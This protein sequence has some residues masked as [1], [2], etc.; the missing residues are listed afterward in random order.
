MVRACRQIAGYN[1]RWFGAALVYGT[2]HP[3]GGYGVSSSG[4]GWEEA[5][6]RLLTKSIQLN[7][8]SQTMVLDYK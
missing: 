5:V 2:I 6:G 4:E 3:K 1:K 7:L 8:F